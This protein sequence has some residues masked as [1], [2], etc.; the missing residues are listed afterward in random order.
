MPPAYLGRFGK[1]AT[2]YIGSVALAKRAPGC[3]AEQALRLHAEAVQRAHAPSARGQKRAAE[4]GQPSSERGGW[5]LICGVLREAV[6]SRH[7][8][9]AC[10]FCILVLTYGGSRVQQKVAGS[11]AQFPRG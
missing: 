10:I 7:K 5:L 4:L 1:G 9:L 11:A 2:G 3:R 6:V 8:Q